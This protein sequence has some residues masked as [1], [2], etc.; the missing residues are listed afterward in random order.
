MSKE[1]VA[2]TLARWEQLLAAWEANPGDLSHLEEY[3]VELQ[4][5]VDRIKT[6]GGEQDAL[7]ARKQQ[8]TRDLDTAKERGREIA[9]RVRIG[10]RS[11]YGDSG[12]KLIEFGLKPRRGA[13][14]PL[15]RRPAE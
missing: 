9:V 4:E 12:E 2:M 8:V 5:L 15:K 1:S 13:P 7:N 11:R 3:R 10:I 14:R 6:L